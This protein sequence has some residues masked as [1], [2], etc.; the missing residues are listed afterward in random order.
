M[1]FAW[2]LV[3]CLIRICFVQS[4]S[5][6][7][8]VTVLQALV[9]MLHSPE[10]EHPLRTDVADEYMKDPKKFMKNAEEHTRKYAEKP[11]AV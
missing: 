9:A 8:P 6:T 10:L 5:Y 4:S 2:F 11:P 1:P 7:F 3:T